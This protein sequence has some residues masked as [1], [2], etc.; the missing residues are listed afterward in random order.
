VNTD[1]RF[2]KTRNECRSL[3]TDSSL[4]NSNDK[5]LLMEIVDRYDVNLVSELS[6]VASET[7][8]LDSNGYSIEF[9]D[10]GPYQIMKGPNPSHGYVGT[11][12]NAHGEFLIASN[13]VFHNPYSLVKAIPILMKI[14]SDAFEGVSFPLGSGVVYTTRWP[15]SY[16]HLVDE[17]FTT[18]A[19]KDVIAE[20]MDYLPLVDFPVYTGI[21]SR[22]LLANVAQ[23]SQAIFQ[24]GSLNLSAVKEPSL[25][26]NRLALIRN[27][28]SDTCFHRF[29]TAISKRIVKLFE[30]N[31]DLADEADVREFVFLTRGENVD[32]KRQIPDL[33]AMIDEAKSRGFRVMNPEHSTLQTLVRVISSCKGLVCSWGGALTNAAFLKPESRVGI[34]KL[35]AYQDEPLNL[36]FGHMIEEHAL[37]T[38]VMHIDDHE[39]NLHEFRLLLDWVVGVQEKHT[40]LGET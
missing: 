15:P 26:V 29:P 4:L 13:H 10:N 8:T 3:I 32:S 36:I 5:E 27:R 22:L 38:K 39:G 34:L 21:T 12:L 19:A 7:S 33:D 24:G 37:S 25:T 28:T 35:E 30:V 11:A 40:G 2:E 16:G 20:L 23:M 14:R 1:P 17:M 6:F 31:N 9:A 18:A